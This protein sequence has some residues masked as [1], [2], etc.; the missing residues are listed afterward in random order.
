[1]TTVIKKS[2][3]F[4]FIESRRPGVRSCRV[5]ST[6]ESM[7]QNL[8]MVEMVLNAEVE[9]HR[10]E[11]SESFLVLEGELEIILENERQRLGRE[12]VCYFAPGESHGVK[13]LSPKARFLV[14]FAPARR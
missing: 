3:E 14:V 8:M 11:N 7:E 12:D 2:S 1:M 9:Y 5:I 4:Q 6:N 13:C 10:V